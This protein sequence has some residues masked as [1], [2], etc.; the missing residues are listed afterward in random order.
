MS[1]LTKILSDPTFWIAV[2]AVLQGVAAIIAYSALRYSVTTFTK[3]LAVSNYTEL[4]RMYFD[5]LRTAVDK[6]HLINPQA[7]RNDE[8]QREYDT[9][10][11]MVWNV[12]ESIYDRCHGDDELCETWYPVIDTEEL[13]HGNWLDDPKNQTKFKHRFCRFIEKR[14]KKHKGHDHLVTT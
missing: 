1:H 8:Q 7:V 5:L 11:F 3:T 2:G 6:P 4:D 14:Y 9:Y 12:M 10:A 13:R